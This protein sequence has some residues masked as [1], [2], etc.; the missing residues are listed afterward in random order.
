[1]WRVK[2]E[3]ELTVN[4]DMIAKIAIDFKW[5][6]QVATVGATATLQ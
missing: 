2:Y 5:P 3:I 4:S 6:E 1:M